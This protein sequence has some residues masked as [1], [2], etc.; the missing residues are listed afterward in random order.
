MFWPIAFH[1]KFSALDKVGRPFRRL[2]T[3]HRVILLFGAA[4]WLASSAE[5]LREA[6]L[7]V[8]DKIRKGL[9]EKELWW[10]HG[11]DF[12]AAAL[13]AISA[14]AREGNTIH[15]ALDTGALKPFREAR[16]SR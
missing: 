15:G 8:V 14:S 11:V 2:E 1:A 13:Q 10:T 4:D 3:M 5:A 9:F 16:L 12:Q 6:R 7:S